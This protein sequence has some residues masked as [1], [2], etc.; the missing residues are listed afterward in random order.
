[1]GQFSVTS[2]PMPGFS[3]ALSFALVSNRL[4][5]E[6]SL[7]LQ[8]ASEKLLGMGLGEGHENVMKINPCAY[9]DP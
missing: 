2:L 1:M 5:G 3:S 9:V 6:T 7:D 8:E 4:F